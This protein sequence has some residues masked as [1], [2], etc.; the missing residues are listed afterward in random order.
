L[1][2][3]DEEL[4]SGAREAELDGRRLSRSEWASTEFKLDGPRRCS[5][6]RDGA[7]VPCDL[8]VT[9]PPRPAPE[10]P[11]QPAVSVTELVNL[12]QGLPGKK[13]KTKVEASKVWLTQ[14]ARKSPRGED[15]PSAWARRLY[16]MPGAKQ[17]WGG[18]DSLRVKLYEYGFVRKS[19]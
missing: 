17:F 6:V 15:D 1:R 18:W 11:P 12:L 13:T 7:L 3:I 4:R 2:I 16:K 5:I 10:P 9:D 14:A 19:E 8:W